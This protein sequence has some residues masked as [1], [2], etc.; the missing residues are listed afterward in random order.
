VQAFAVF[1]TTNNRFRAEFSTGYPIKLKEYAGFIGQHGFWYKD[2]SPS[3]DIYHGETT[4]VR[5]SIFLQSHL[6]LKFQVTNGVFFTLGSRYLLY[7]YYSVF[8]PTHIR[9]PRNYFNLSFGLEYH[10]PNKEEN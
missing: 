1:R 6:R 10:F 5:N 2:I 8:S 9:A 4:R 3:S 7:S